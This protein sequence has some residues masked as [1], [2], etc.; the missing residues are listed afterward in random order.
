MEESV[1]ALDAPA[2][3]LKRRRRSRGFNPLLVRDLR[4]RM[5]GAR[6][7]VV[8]TVYI[9]VLGCFA[10]L[11]YGLS[12]SSPPLGYTSVLA[13]AGKTLFYSVAIIEL[14]MVAF[15]TPA[16]TA[17]AISGE[18]ERKTYDLLRATL[19]PARK[20]VLGK[21]ASAWVFMALLILVAAPLE[22]MAFMMGGV[23]AT[24]LVLAQVVLLTMAA[25]SAAL[26]I[27][28]SSLARTTLV[29][30]VLTYAS[31]LLTMV[32]FPVL[33]LIFSGFFTY[34]DLPASWPM[35]WQAVV[36]YAVYGLLCLNPLAVAV[37]IEVFLE[38]NAVFYHVLSIDGGSVWLPAPWIVFLVFSLLGVVVLLAM[39]V[40]RVRRQEEQ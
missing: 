17:G 14:F 24:E 8:L 33:A 4:G 3:A 32:G 38:S 18:R 25:T 13:T 27:L 40:L 29:S 7:F 22:S 28:V 12:I 10:V 30:T 11:I 34:W 5:R 9:L 35:V 26:G 16:F 6:A 23:V 2:P 37:L 39:A 36:I 1:A 31:A 20:L 19:L 21:F 15:I